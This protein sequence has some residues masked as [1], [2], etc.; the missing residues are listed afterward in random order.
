MYQVGVYEAIQNV[1]QPEPAGSTGAGSG[2]RGGSRDAGGVSFILLPTYITILHDCIIHA[3]YVTIMYAGGDSFILLPTYITTLHDYTTHALHVTIMHAG[4]ESF[5]LLT[6]AETPTQPPQLLERVVLIRGQGGEGAA[7]EEGPAGEAITA[8]P[9]PQ[10]ALKDVK[11]ELIKY[12][13]AL[14]GLELS[15]MLYT[16]AGYDVSRYRTASN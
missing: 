12:T 16:P 3:L 10:P 6:T 9:H 4:G 13:R 7:G 14:D 1:I 15:G 5:I 11:K 8:L 2:A